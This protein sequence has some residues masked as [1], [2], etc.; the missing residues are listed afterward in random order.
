[1]D[2]LAAVRVDAE[3]DCLRIVEQPRGD[4][5]DLVD[6]C[7]VGGSLGEVAAARRDE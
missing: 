7:S 6:R 3:V 5:L 2:V 1:V 4:P